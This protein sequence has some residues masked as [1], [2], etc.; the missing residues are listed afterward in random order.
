MKSRKTIRP[1]KCLA[2]IFFAALFLIGC[3]KPEPENSAPIN[4]DMVEAPVD[5]ETLVAP[6]EL[7]NTA[8]QINKE[9]FDKI[10]NGMSL[11]DVEILIAGKNRKVT[12]KN[13][14]GVLKETYRWETEDGTRY[15][16]VSFDDEKVVGKSQKGLK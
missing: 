1:L 7:E 3:S 5:P 11:W 16:E 8:E 15:I 6:V 2:L 10:K 12:S 4:R 9:N 13:Q 14:A